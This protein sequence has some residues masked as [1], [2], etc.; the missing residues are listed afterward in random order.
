MVGFPTESEE[1]FAE[2]VSFAQKIGFEK[3]HV[4][5]YSP[6][7]GTKAAKMP[8][9]ERSVKEK[10]S[11]IMIEKTEEV[12]QN[13]LHEQIGKTVEVLFETR[14]SDGFVEGYTKNYTPVKIKKE[15]PCGVISKVK[16]TDV[17]GDF[18]VGEEL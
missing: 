11:H 17:D 1:D 12:R 7:E 18:C 9:I 13:F 14:H 2:N 16:I 15:V 10:R 8:Q 3:V 4:F 6:R 5:P